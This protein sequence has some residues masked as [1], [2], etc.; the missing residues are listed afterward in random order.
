M[1]CIWDVG[2]G[3]RV[4]DRRNEKKGKERQERRMV[5]KGGTRGDEKL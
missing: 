4:D 3:R 5:E 1:K 2:E